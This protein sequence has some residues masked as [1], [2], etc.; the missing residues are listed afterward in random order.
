M[1]IFSIQPY[2]TKIG[3]KN[4][5]FCA[6]PLLTNNLSFDVFSPQNSNKSDI[7]WIKDANLLQ[8]VRNLNG[9]EFDKNEV[10]YI[11]S[12]GIV[13]P[14]LKGNDAINFIKKNRIGVEFAPLSSDNIHAQYDY[15]YNCILI[16]EKYKNEKDPAVLLAISEAILHEAGHAKDY[17]GETSVQEEIDC[18]ALNAL[19]HRT[20]DKKYH[21]IFAQNNSP[22]VK[23]GVCVYPELFFD[24]DPL[25]QALVNRLSQKYGNLA[26]GDL[27]HSPCILAIK[28]KEQQN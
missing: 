6:N 25:K 12:L 18:L 20:F 8:S 9:L 2:N 14:F 10:H 3:Q 5:S 24:D 15:D 17:D 27:L 16:N 22:I 19:S 11:Q 21:D 23:D 13:L 4:Q 1:K 7:P 26:A 28:V